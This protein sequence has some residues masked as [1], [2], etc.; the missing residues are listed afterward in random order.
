MRRKTRRVQNIIIEI[1][2][3]EGGKDRLILYNGLATVVGGI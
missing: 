2:K 3:N 1:T